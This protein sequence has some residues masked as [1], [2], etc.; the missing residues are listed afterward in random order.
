MLACN[1]LVESGIIQQLPAHQ[2]HLTNSVTSKLVKV[3]HTSL[4][5]SLKEIP[6]EGGALFHLLRSR[7]HV[8]SARPQCA[9]RHQS[10][11]PGGAAISER[12]ASAASTPRQLPPLMPRRESPHSAGVETIRCGQRERERERERHGQRGRPTRLNASLVEMPSLTAEAERLNNAEG[13]TARRL[14]Y[15]A[16]RD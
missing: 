3:K 8:H 5:V 15:T 13:S 6:W 12:L 1:T 7:P 14:S 16:G 2:K 9:A 4:S 10:S 11:A